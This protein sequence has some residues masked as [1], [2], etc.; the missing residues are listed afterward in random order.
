[1]YLYLIFFI[2]TLLSFGDIWIEPKNRGPKYKLI[3]AFT[4]ICLFVLSAFR[5]EMGTD[6]DRYEEYFDASTWGFDGWMEYGFT[7]LN[8]LVYSISS[9]YSVMVFVVA[10]IV[11]TL[12]PQVIYKLAPY[13]FLALL[14]WYVVGIADIFPVRQTISSALLLYSIIFVINKKIWPFLMIV[15]LASLFHSTALIFIVTYFIFDIRISRLVSVTA[16]IGSFIFAVTAQAAISDLLG[17]ISNPI[18]QEKLNAYL[19]MGADETFGSIYSSRQVIIRGFVNRGLIMFI[20]FVLLNNKNKEDRVLNG[21]VNMFV[22]SSLCYFILCSVNIALGRLVSYFDL[23]QIFIFTY[24]FKLRMTP[25]NK[26]VLFGMLIIYLLYR[27]YGV[28]NNYYDLY[29]PYTSI[30]YRANV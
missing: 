5:L 16:F 1:M 10:S 29:V 17:A 3:F 23:S 27:F 13:P 21:W 18:L 30:F 26:L 24:L 6:W 8:K 11:Y 22:F 15:I 20:V 7:L 9:N 4:I 19:S 14:M 28:V 12:K 2:L 25:V